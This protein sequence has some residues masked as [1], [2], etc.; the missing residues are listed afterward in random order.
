MAEVM[1]EKK[2]VKSDQNLLASKKKKSKKQKQKD[3]YDE[4][5][6]NFAGLGEL[7]EVGRPDWMEQVDSSDDNEGGLVNDRRNFDLGRP[8]QGIL[9]FDMLIYFP[10]D[11]DNLKTLLLYK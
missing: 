10:F 7:G 11:S 5:D 8:K 4:L 3:N 1:V 9:F 2:K 6:N